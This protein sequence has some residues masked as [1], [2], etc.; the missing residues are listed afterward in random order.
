MQ[1]IE[2]ARDLMRVIS[3][4]AAATP[5]QRDRAAAL[6]MAFDGNPEPARD[7]DM[8]AKLAVIL[9]RARGSFYSAT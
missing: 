1:N 6:A 4:C 3:L 8:I 2:S 7:Q 9:D 5:T